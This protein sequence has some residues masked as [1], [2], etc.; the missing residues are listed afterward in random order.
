MFRLLALKYARPFAATI[1]VGVP[2]VTA[3]LAGHAFLDEPLTAGFALG[4][5]LVFLGVTLAVLARH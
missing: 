1:L 2:P 5:S 3:V 4:L